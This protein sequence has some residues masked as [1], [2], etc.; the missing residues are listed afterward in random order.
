MTINQSDAPPIEFGR[1]QCVIRVGLVSARA[2]WRAV[3]VVAS[4][5]IGA[6]VI[7][8]LAIGVG[9][10]T[11]APADVLG[12]LLGTNTSFDRVVV[13]EWRLPRML[14]ALLVGAALG[15]SG[16][17]FQALTRNP[18]GSPDIIGVNTGAYTGALIVIA[19]IGGGYYAVAAGALVGGLVT[20]VVVY[21]LSYRNGVAGF[22]LIVVGIAVSAVISS[23][24]QWIVLKIDLH[25]AV[26]ASV[27]QQGTLNGLSWA[28]VSPMTSCLLVGA[29]VLVTL[30]P[31]LPILQL[32]DDAA[33][34]LGVQPDRARLAYLVVGVG[35]VAIA[36]AAAGPVS[37]VALAAPQIARRLVASPGVGLVP[38]AATG[39]VLLLVSDVIAQQLFSGSELPV[40]A[41]TVSLG[42]VYLVYLLIS[43]A[44]QR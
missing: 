38:S 2:S 19:G 25:T 36:C 34:A 32:G 31:Q 44:R 24:N 43:Q 22:R 13:L 33:G 37:F 21:A 3:I 9:E 16:A 41:V 30:G 11:I 14:M 12:V 6:V 27:W 40:G 29:V 7:A 35:L 23:V 1:R 20:A 4:L 39:S 17:I 26:T 18:L 10:Y 28:Q 8:V 15:V 42:G 5:L